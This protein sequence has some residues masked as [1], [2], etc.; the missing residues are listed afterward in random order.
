MSDSNT[1][2]LVV[3]LGLRSNRVIAFDADGTKLDEA[4]EQIETRVSAARVEQ[5]PDEW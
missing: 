3:N 5:D 1:C 4:S 2:Y